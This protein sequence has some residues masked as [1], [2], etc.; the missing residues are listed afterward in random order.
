MSEM[1]S[2]N[3][4]HA[5]FVLIGTGATL[6]QLM[7][8]DIG[9]IGRVMTSPNATFAHLSGNADAYL[10]QSV[11]VFL[12]SSV[13]A[14]IV[15][16]PYG[17]AFGYEGESDWGQSLSHLASI[18]VS[19]TVAPLVV[20]LVGRRL[21]GSPHWKQTFVVLFHANVLLAVAAVPVA[22]LVL[23]ASVESGM[24][25]DVSALQYD[26]PY[27]YVY[28][29]IVVAISVWILVVTVK[30]TKVVHSFGTAKAFGVIVLSIGVS[31]TASA[32]FEAGVSLVRG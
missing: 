22:A 11:A 13:L 17:V 9:I 32:I 19:G 15:I 3:V 20:H 27:A 29:S 7:P 23:V 4:F 26:V 12:V 28:Y 1:R 16:I 24:Q 21:G 5:G 2:E 8:F 6:G 14:A 31:Y 30:A 25:Y 18:L 10:G